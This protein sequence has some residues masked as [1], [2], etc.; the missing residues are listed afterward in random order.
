MV[1]QSDVPA[2]IEFGHFSIFPH[3]R[4]LLAEGRPIALGGRAFDVLMALI[5]GSGA[6][7]SKE[8]LL[9]RI[10][11]GRIVD[12][13]RLAS[14]IA[15]LRKAFG[16][17][18]ELIRTVVGRGYQFTGEIRARSPGRERR[19]PKAAAASA[20]PSR[21]PTNLP[22]PVSDLI[23]RE[24]ELSEVIDL[25]TT[26]RLVTLIGEGGI[27]KTRLGLE[28]GRHLIT[29][30]ADGVWVAELASLSD[31]DLV[32]VTVATALEA[33]SERRS[34]VSR[35]RR[36]VRSPRGSSCCCCSTIASM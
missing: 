27:G 16:A 2:S 3:R 28:V 14:Q 19:A 23:G 21:H 9:S 36:Q 26:H 8:D 33:R 7:V 6:V 11:Q 4:Q 5:E 18:R 10:W 32:P 24:T 25:V 15:A 1:R 12:E 34:S 22:E 17:D 31:P 20:R 29:E 35:A 30:F 13:N